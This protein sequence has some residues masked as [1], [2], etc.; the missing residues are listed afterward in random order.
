MARLRQLLAVPDPRQQNK[1]A[2]AAYEDL[3]PSSRYLKHEDLHA[4]LVTGPLRV[5]SR[6]AKHAVNQKINY[7]KLQKDSD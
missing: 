4:T 2:T 7:K 6:F 1:S 3:M 5:E